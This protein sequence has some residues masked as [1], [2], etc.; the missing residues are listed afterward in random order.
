[1]EYGAGAVVLWHQSAMVCRITIFED[2]MV[3]DIN[4][5]RFSSDTSL[6]LLTH[7]LSLRVFLMR[8][9]HWTVDEFLN[10]YNPPNAVPL[11]WARPVLPVGMRVAC[12]ACPSWL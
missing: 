4:A 9:F 5:G 6:V 3:R 8:W 11:V 12:R 1:M 7:G 10:V 2:H